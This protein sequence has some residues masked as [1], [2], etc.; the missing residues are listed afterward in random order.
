MQK[1]FVHA[2]K[3]LAQNISMKIGYTRYK[4]WQ[5]LFSTCQT[6]NKFKQNSNNKENAK[7]KIII[8]FNK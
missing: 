7:Q 6:N 8:L 4:K 5:K 2:Y 1:L 3:Q